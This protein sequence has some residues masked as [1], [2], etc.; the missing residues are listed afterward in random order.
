MRPINTKLF[1]F[2]GY[3][4]RADFA[5]QSIHLLSYDSVVF[6]FFVSCFALDG[7]KNSII[8]LEF[9]DI[10]RNCL[11]TPPKA[12][13]AVGLRNKTKQNKRRNKRRIG[14]QLPIRRTHKM[15][16]PFDSLS[17]SAYNS[18]KWIAYRN[19]NILFILNFWWW[20]VNKQIAKR[21]C[22]CN[23]IVW[24]LESIIHIRKMC[25]LLGIRFHVDT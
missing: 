20:S 25:V 7:K 24:P 6:F 5:L 3:F 4:H 14:K 19:R 21:I 15:C 12:Q 18:W 2:L 10:S 23:T 11:S 16:A 8:L 17:S 13:I 22:T 1:Y 9:I